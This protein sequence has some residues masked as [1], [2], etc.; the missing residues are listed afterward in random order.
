MP[1]VDK[2]PSTASSASRPLNLKLR[3]DITFQKQQYQGRDYWLAKDPIALNYF[4]FEEEEYR[5]LRLMD[6]TVTPEQIKLRFDY[7]FAPQKISMQE[8]YQFIGMLYRSS[9]LVSESPDQGI[10]LLKRGIKNKKQE[11]RQSLTFDP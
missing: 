3:A 6:G 9:L 11:R 5:L 4:R 7:E 10:E 1:T 2:N 8:L